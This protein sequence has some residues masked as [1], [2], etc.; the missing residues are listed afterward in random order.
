MW[1]WIFRL[2]TI[3]ILRTFFN[4]KVEGLANVPKKT[5]FIVVANHTS[6]LDPFVIGAVI[7]QKI[8]WIAFKGLY[9][10]PFV[11][12]FLF[13]VGTL[14]DGNASTKLLYLVTHNK[15]VGVFP[16]GARTHEGKLRHFRRGAALLS[17]KTGRPILPC[18]ILGA[19]EAYPAKAKF[20]KPFSPIK[21]KIG[22][23]RYLLKEFDDHIDDI[24]LQDGTL[25][26][27]KT[28][29]EMM[30]AG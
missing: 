17:V 15:N 25:R 9:K 24:V 6:Y 26:I 27:Q 7:P 23:P 10:A 20:P 21:V 18:A 29:Q 8:Y 5:N 2:L 12:W 30:Y 13:K 4:L 3:V 28:I 14:P 11:N 1:Y 22:T 19:H 16:E